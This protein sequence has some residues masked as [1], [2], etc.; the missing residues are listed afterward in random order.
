MAD[1]K[2]EALRRKSRG[3]RSRENKG[4]FR[5]DIRASRLLKR[6]HGVKAGYAAT[7]EDR[8]AALQLANQR[9]TIKPESVDPTRKVTKKRKAI[10]G[11]FEAIDTL[12]GGSEGEINNTAARGEAFRI[13]ELAERMGGAKAD[14]LEEMANAYLETFRKNRKIGTG[15]GFADAIG[16]LRDIQQLMN[17]LVNV[18]FLTE[19]YDLSK[20]SGSALTGG[21]TV[22]QGT[23][24]LVFG[25]SY[26]TA[27]KE[28]EQSISNWEADI[29]SNYE[30]GSLRF[31]NDYL[32]QQQSRIDTARSTSLNEE[33]FAAGEEDVPWWA[34]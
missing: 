21:L 7:A 5:D 17:D 11:A 26:N 16:H 8:A 14:E 30:P 23:N 25:K 27:V 18:D 15:Q 20:F 9:L 19:N 24:E 2:R 34:R 6:R 4:L 22:G 31:G 13:R 32:T 1:P 33:D 3:A 10:A 28:R 29:Q 12:I